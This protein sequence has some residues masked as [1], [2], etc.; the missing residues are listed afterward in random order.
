MV[1]VV[2]HI[3]PDGNDADVLFRQI[4]KLGKPL[5]R[6]TGESAQVF[7][8]QNIIIPAHQLRSESLPVVG[9]LFKGVPRAVAVFVI[10]HRTCREM[11]ATVIP[12]NRFLVFDT[13][14]V[15]VQLQINRN[16]G[17]CRNL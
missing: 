13:R 3:I 14:V 1:L 6:P 10:I 7:D 17:V 15:L 2:V 4:L 8:N 9:A 12:D 11:Q 5:A 16:T